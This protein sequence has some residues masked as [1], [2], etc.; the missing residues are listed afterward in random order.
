MLAA[1]FLES[2]HFDPELVTRHFRSIQAAFETKRAQGVVRIYLLNC[3]IAQEDD[4]DFVD[5]YLWPL[6]PATLHAPNIRLRPV[7]QVE[8]TELHKLARQPRVEQLPISFGVPEVRRVRTVLEI[9]FAYEL[10]RLLNEAA[11]DRRELIADL[12]S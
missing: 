3:R 5:R 4:R 1:C 6:P 10:P 11:D 8:M 2:P 12:L 7:T 9:F